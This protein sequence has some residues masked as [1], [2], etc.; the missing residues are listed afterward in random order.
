MA[1]VSD[2]SVQQKKDPDEVVKWNEYEALRDY[3]KNRIAKSAEDLQEDL[4]R[5]ELKVDGAATQDS[6]AALQESMTAL[7]RQITDLT[8]LVNQR[9]PGGNV[10]ANAN[11][12]F[13][14]EGGRER[15]HAAA[16]GRGFHA[17]GARR[18]VPHDNNREDDGLGKPK[19]SIPRFEGSPDVEKYLTWEL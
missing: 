7:T 19:F 5:V 2:D 10:N 6:V 15:G 12:E 18:V 9:G 13:D 1:S 14:L 3:L 17:F 4:Q 8:T 16:P 11:E